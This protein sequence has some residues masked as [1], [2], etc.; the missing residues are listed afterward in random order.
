MGRELVRC[1]GGRSERRDR[2]AQT[3]VAHRGDHRRPRGG[4]ELHA[5]DADT[6]GG[7][8]DADALTHPQ[9]ALREQRIVRGR[10][11]LGKP[12]GLG[13]RDGRRERASPWRSC[14]T[15]S[16]AWPPPP[17]TAMTRSPS[18][19]ARDSVA[20]RHDLAGELEAGD[21]LRASRRCRVEALPL[22]QVGA[23]DAG[24]T[25]GDEQL[26]RARHRVRMLV[27]VERAVDDRYGTHY[28]ASIGT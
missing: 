11:H 4:R 14:T 25:H 10:E 27:P 26:A 23:V 9:S 21:V 8:V 24:S 6:A 17:T 15:A 7:A 2:V 5:G 19:E 16:S 12:T 1:D 28:L 20:D 22:H 18:G 3:F 13:P